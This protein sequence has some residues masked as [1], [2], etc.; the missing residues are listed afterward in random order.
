[1]TSIYQFE[2]GETD[3]EKFIRAGAAAIITRAGHMQLVRQAAKDGPF[4]DQLRDVGEGPG[5]LAGWTLSDLARGCLERA[6]KASG[7]PAID[8]VKRALEVRGEGSNTTSDFAILLESAARNISLGF[9]AATP[10]TFRRW[11]GIKSLQDF[12]KAKFYRAGSFGTLDDAPEGGEIKFKNIPDGEAA[13]LTLGTKGNIVGLTRKAIVN[14]DLSIFR[15]LMSAIGEAAARTIEKAAFDLVRANAG[16]GPTLADTKA[17][18]HADHKNVGGAGALSVDVF[19]EAMALL[20]GQTDP[21][22]SAL[23]FA[24]RVWLGPV[25]LAPTVRQFNTSTADPTTGKNSGVGNPL[26]GI[27]GDVVGASHLTGTRSYVFADPTLNPTFAVG[28]LNGQEGPL[29]STL[30]QG[31][32]DGTRWRCLLDFAVGAFDFRTAVTLPGA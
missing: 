18:F 8:V 28:F 30:P 16:M 6:G 27:F 2:A 25:K 3:R 11:C 24:P 26:L 15:E 31:S 10:A 22:G 1:M 13:D 17:L 9:Y 12:R 4:A 29:I 20:A 5:D 7:G 14:D 32:Y 21:Q 23:N 19:G